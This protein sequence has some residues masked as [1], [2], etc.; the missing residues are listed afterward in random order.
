MNYIYDVKI[1]PFLIS[2]N[3]TENIINKSLFNISE[4]IKE[5]QINVCVKYIWL[6]NVNLIQTKPNQ[7]LMSIV[8]YLIWTSSSVI[9][10]TLAR[11][12]WGLP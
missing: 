7:E 11:L 8:L 12:S 6:T 10:E 1:L 3:Q 9:E 4:L 5:S 2:S